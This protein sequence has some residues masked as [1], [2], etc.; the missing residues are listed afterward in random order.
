MRT[1]THKS[2]GEQWTWS[3]SCSRRC[4][5]TEASTFYCLNILLPR[6][7]VCCT[8]CIASHRIA[9]EPAPN[10]FHVIRCRPYKRCVLWSSLDV[11]LYPLPF[12][13]IFQVYTCC[14][15]EC[16]VQQVSWI[17]RTIFYRCSHIST[18]NYSSMEH[19][20]L[21]LTVP[22]QWRV[23][24]CSAAAREQHLWRGNARTSSPPSEQCQH[25]G[26][27]SEGEHYNGWRCKS[28]R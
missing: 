16:T 5:D 22:F 28:S 23:G 24:G 18:I 19:V 8:V 27:Q 1:R 21:T 6:H 26:A 7:L 11:I 17:H 2:R 13:L 9:V 4:W 14:E 12:F 25:R 3:C 10:G 20:F 15:R